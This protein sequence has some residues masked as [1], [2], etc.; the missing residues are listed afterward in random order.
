MFGRRESSVDFYTPALSAILETPKMRRA[1]IVCDA[2]T[3]G[4]AEKVRDGASAAVCELSGGEEA[5]NW[6]SVERILRAAME[7]SIGRDDIFL[8]VG[9]G[10]VSDICGFAASIYKRGAVYMIVSTTLLG[11]ADAALGG[12][13]GFDLFDIKNFAGTFY[14]ARHIWMPPA[15][16]ATLPP[17]EWRSGLA[18]I[19]KTAVIDNSIYKQKTREQILALRP[20]L[21]TASTL[22]GE[23]GTPAETAGI[24]DA[25]EPLIRQAVKVKGRIVESDPEERFGRRD[26]L[27][28]GHT[29]AH[30]LESAAGLGRLSHGEAVAWG[31]VR[32]CELGVELKVTPPEKTEII[33]SVITELGYETRAPHPETAGKASALEF[34][35]ALCG[36]KK[37]KGGGFRF[38][39]PARRGASLVTIDEKDLKLI[40]KT[41]GLTD[42]I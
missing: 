34:M 6:N 35:R 2:N 1:I 16:L 8:A 7:A 32:A 11:M 5:K 22:D 36:D 29:F 28:L 18:E 10:V 27:N 24:I 40:E 9:G 4:F 31:M 38:V 23:T 15:A 25:A 26:V 3:A 42:L 30:A 12:K 39:V 14:P 37:K 19:I 13:T 21:R 20:A 17:R 41:A 33:R